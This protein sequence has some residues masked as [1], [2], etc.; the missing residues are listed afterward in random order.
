M[1]DRR[2]S[3]PN[4]TTS[5]VRPK[6]IPPDR[7]IMLRTRMQHAVDVAFLLQARTAERDDDGEID[8]G[9]I[10]ELSEQV[11]KMAVG[12]QSG[13]YKKFHVASFD[14]PTANRGSEDDIREY[15]AN[16]RL[17]HVEDK[18]LSLVNHMVRFVNAAYGSGTLSILSSTLE[19]QRSMRELLEKLREKF[20]STEWPEL[21]S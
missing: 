16:L 18:Y 12:R 8:D 5:L 3:T 19:S 20:P 9:E 4:A 21:P 6:K 15:Y 2:A 10:D 13:Y 11:A 14:V 1:R 17:K 7:A